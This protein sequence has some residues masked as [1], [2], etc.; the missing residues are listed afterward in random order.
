MSERIDERIIT[1]EWLNQ[2]VLVCR[3]LC[4]GP[5]EEYEKGKQKYLDFREKI[6][7]QRARSGKSRLNDYDI[8]QIID[9]AEG[10]FEVKR[11]IKINH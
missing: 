10:T 7:Q 1:P 4:N 11:I 5:Q 8:R 2:K 6:N 9:S 3:F